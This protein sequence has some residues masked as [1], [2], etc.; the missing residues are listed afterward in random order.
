M[1]NDLAR[2]FLAGSEWRAKNAKGILPAQADERFTW[3]F[4]PDLVIMPRRIRMTSSRA[5]ARVPVH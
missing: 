1:M 4:G 3:G 2:D 5:P